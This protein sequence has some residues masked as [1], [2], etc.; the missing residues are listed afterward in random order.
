M[1]ITTITAGT[2]ASGKPTDC[3]RSSR[4]ASLNRASVKIAA[5]PTITQ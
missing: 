1:F 2:T 4:K 3:A 5:T